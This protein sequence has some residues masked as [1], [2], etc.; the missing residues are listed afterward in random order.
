[1]GFGERE[2][3]GVVG[4]VVADQGR[5]GF[6]DDGVVVAV[7]DYGALLAPGVELVLLHVN[8][9]LFISYIS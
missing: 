4:F 7:G 8:K 6:D 9:S 3:R 1:M 2:E 5:V